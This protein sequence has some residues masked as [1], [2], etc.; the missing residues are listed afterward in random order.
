MSQTIVSGIGHWGEALASLRFHKVML[1]VGSTFK[2][3]QLGQVVLDSL[4]VP[5]V[6]FDQY[7]PNPL[8]ED[9]CKGVELFNCEA[10]DAIIAV[11]GGSCMDVAKCIKLFCKMNHARNYLEQEP[12]DTQVPLVAIPTTAGTGSESTRFAVI[13]Y[14]GTKQSVNHPSIIPNVAVLE[15]SVL[16]ALPQY[17]K[18]CTVMDA[19]CQA[20]ESWWSVNATPESQQLSGQAIKILTNK[21]LPYTQGFADSA[22]L[23]EVMRGANLAGQAINLTQTTAPHAFS[24]KLT[25]LYQLPHG[26]AVAVCLPKIWRYMLEFPEKCIDPRG[27][28]YLLDVFAHIAQ[29]MDCATA[30]EAVQKYEA[31]MCIM[32]LGNPTSAQRQYDLEVLATSVNPVRLKNNPVALDDAAILSLYSSIVQ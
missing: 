28:A 6:V 22:M 24:Y 13:Y 26:H 16:E 8:Y 19:Y 7:T 21:I 18:K 3:S 11:G 31:M 14:Q 2:R 9:V 5:Y 12:F 30:L 32:G 1:V 29:A 25:S 4:Q 27:S 20:I 23:A 10:C 17:Q 15:P